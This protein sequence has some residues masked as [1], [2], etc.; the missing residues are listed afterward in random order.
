MTNLTIAIKLLNPGG[1]ITFHDAVSWD[2]VNQALKELE[3]KYKNQARIKVYGNKKIAKLFK[4]I[5]RSI[6]GIGCFELL[7]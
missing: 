6:D 2:G 3:E 7:E 4:K 5:N 1:C